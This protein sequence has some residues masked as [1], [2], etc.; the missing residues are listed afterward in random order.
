LLLDARYHGG[1]AWMDT[2]KQV[3][4]RECQSILIERQSVFDLP[5]PKHIVRATAGKWDFAFE[6]PCPIKW[7]VI[8]NAPFLRLITID[9]KRSSGIGAWP[10]EGKGPW[11]NGNIRPLVE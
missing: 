8:Y 6:K 4:R 7:L 2:L 3:W 10:P 5:G 1:K 9:Y 11:K